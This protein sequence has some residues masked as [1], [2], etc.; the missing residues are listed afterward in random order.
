MKLAS[1]VLVLQLILHE[2][3]SNCTPFPAALCGKRPI[4]VRGNVTHST[5]SSNVFKNL[6]KVDLDWF[7]DNFSG[8]HFTSKTANSMTPFYGYGPATSR[9]Q[10]HYKEKAYF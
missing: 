7:C 8:S 2:I 9:L 10:D 6:C 5:K 4:K 1:V 3:E